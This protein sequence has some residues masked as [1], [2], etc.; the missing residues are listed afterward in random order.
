MPT[1][2]QEDGESIVEPD[3]ERDKTPLLASRAGRTRDFVR[4]RLR[5]MINR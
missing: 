5:R 1:L 4:V 2:D 3:L